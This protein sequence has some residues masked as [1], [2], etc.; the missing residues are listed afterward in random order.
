VHTILFLLALCRGFGG[1]LCSLISLL[2][3]FIIGLSFLDGLFFDNISL[4]V[5]CSFL[6]E[7]R[8][9]FG[10]LRVW[11]DDRGRSKCTRSC[12]GEVLPFPS[13]DVGPG[14]A[15]QSRQK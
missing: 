8:A 3:C 10:R 1:E 15:H 12:K 13:F 4:P 2:S 7:C 14:Y 5:V 6:L 11:D 9:F